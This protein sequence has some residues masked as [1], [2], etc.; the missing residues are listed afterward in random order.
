MEEMMTELLDGAM[1][2]MMVALMV[3]H[4]VE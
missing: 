4:W 2:E 1:D 3:V